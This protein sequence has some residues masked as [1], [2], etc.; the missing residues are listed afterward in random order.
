[1]TNQE[2]ALRNQA[3]ITAALIRAGTHR[4]FIGTFETADLAHNAYL[5]AKRE[6]HPGCTL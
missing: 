6:L 3:G 2:A 5:A 1:M 4:R